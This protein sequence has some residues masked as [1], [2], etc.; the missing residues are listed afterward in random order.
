M[1][2]IHAEDIMIRLDS[3]PHVPHWFS[4]RQAIVEMEKTQFEVDGR[5]SLPRVVLVFDKEYRLIGMARRRDILRGLGPDAMQESRERAGEKDPGIKRDLRPGE[6]GRHTTLEELAKRAERPVSDVMT[7][8]RAT[9]AADTPLMEVANF[10]AINDVSIVP[11]VKNGT[12]VG[13]VRSTDVLHWIA[14]AIM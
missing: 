8:I 14:K 9:L 7:P 11:I 4:L 2:N 13:M 12:V 10:M 3:Y 6:A 1:E 5:K